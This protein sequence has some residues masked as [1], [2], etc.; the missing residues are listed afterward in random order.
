M[1]LD[2]TALSKERIQARVSRAL[3]RRDSR[4]EP[5]GSTLGRRSKYRTALQGEADLEIARGVNIILLNATSGVF[6]RP[7]SFRARPFLRP[8][9]ARRLMTTVPRVETLG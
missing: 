2:S 1:Q 7:F 9:R 3:S 8:F 5:R 4:T 6:L